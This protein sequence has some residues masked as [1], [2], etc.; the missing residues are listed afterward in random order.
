MT[1]LRPWPIMLNAPALVQ[2]WAP[3]SAMA[4][5]NWDWRSAKKPS[6]GWPS[7]MRMP[8]TTTSDRAAVVS[9]T[10]PSEVFCATR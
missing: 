7:R 6:T 1:T 4:C 9:P 10:P 3:I 5:K 2:N 8:L